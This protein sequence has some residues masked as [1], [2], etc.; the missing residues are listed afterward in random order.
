MA[1]TP[2]AR[3]QPSAETSQYHH[4]IPRF[5][6][7][8]FSYKSPKK[9]RNRRN[10]RVSDMLYTID[11][12]GPTAQIVDASVDRTFGKFDMYRDFARAENQHYLEDQLSKLESRASAVV[13]TV[14]KTFEAGEKDVWLTRL[15][16]DTLRKFLFIMKY[17]SSNMHRRFHHETP[18]G[19]SADDR[20]GLLKYMRKKGFRRPIDVWF[21]NIKAMLELKMDPKGEW[22]N[23]IRKRAYPDDAE[24]FILH[25]QSMHMAL[26]TPSE[27]EDE[28]L[29]TENGY[30]IHEGPV[31]GQIDP[32]T[33]EFAATYYTEYHVFAVIS[34]RLM[35]VLRSFLLPDPMEDSSQNIR[36]Y[37][38]AMYRHCAG[39]HDDPN[40]ANSILADLPISKALNSYSL[41]TGGRL[42]LRNGEDG[43]K[44]EN[45]RFCFRFF[46][47]AEDHVK[48]INGIMLEES[49]AI[50]TIVFGSPAGAR[51]IIE[52]YLSA[53]PR[54][55]SGFKTV[56]SK[57]DDRRLILLRKLEHIVHGMGSNV[58]AV[59][60]TRMNPLTEE[61]EDEL[62]AQ[63]MDL[64]AS[65]EISEHMQLYMRLGGTYTTLK[66]DLEQA[67]NMLKMRVKFDVWSAGLDEGFRNDIRKNLTDIFSQFPVRR[68]W[69]YL[70]QLRNMFLRGDSKEGDAIVDGPEDMI[71]S[72]MSQVIRSED[73]GR[74]MFA[75]VLNQISLAYHPDFN[76]YPKIISEDLFGSISQSKQ[77]VFSSAG[78]ICNC[79]INEI[80]QKARL[81]RGKLQTPRYFDTFADLFL[82]K[83][84]MIRHPFWSDEEHMEMLT[85]FLTRV[86]FPGL[87]ATLEEEE[88]DGLDEVLFEIAYPCLSMDQLYGAVAV[89]Y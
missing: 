46:P 52:S 3:I 72:G 21:D 11:L 76:I 39:L 74:L 77:I 81:L 23:E 22:M 59:Y 66:K 15:E 32:S 55:E 58:V 38:Q 85:R 75:V 54:A 19:Y 35:I 60:H 61:E 17:R 6:L 25:T 34:P 47:I 65:E 27:Q 44:R 13:A 82:S 29:L 26:C 87:V 5:I 49:Y 50:S 10:Q 37:R 16:R 57:P 51:K 18:E 42:V 78:S 14:R 33:G 20:E 41:L 1:S 53:V 2:T 80:E 43:T 28:F 4:F 24:W 30:G 67:R 83:D 88:E 12:S 62:V 70:K 7:R 64:S 68:V 48:K 69:Y 40:E 31:S 56:S 79:G 71:A 84:A 36:E 63:M 89:A 9:R 86:I 73:I 8:N 45:H